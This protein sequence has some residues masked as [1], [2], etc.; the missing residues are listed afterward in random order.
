MNSQMDTFWA[1]LTNPNGVSCTDNGCSKKLRWTD[2]AIFEWDATLH[3]SLN[4]V[5]ETHAYSYNLSTKAFT[6]H[7][8]TDMMKY[9]CMSECACK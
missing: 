5:P 1:G 7:T 6:A 4:V 2:G 8:N 9:V 3:T